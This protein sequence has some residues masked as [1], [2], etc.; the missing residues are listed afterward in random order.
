MSSR[1]IPP[2]VSAMRRY[3]RDKFLRILCVDFYIDG[4]NACKAFEKKRF[5]LHYWFTRQASKV[6]QP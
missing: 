3:S 6:P 4:I 5:T 2:K 1:L